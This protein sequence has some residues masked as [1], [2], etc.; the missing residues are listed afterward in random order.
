MPPAVQIAY[1]EAA[2]GTAGDAVIDPK[3]NRVLRRFETKE[4]AEAFANS[5]K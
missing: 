2:S 3:T 1:L 4:Q 5:R